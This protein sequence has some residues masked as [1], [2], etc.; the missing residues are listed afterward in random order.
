MHSCLLSVHVDTELYGQPDIHCEQRGPTCDGCG[1]TAEK[2]RRFCLA[3]CT[4]YKDAGDAIS[5]DRARNA[6]D[7]D[8]LSTESISCTT[9]VGQ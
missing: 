5:K 1:R 2:G 9:A 4:A 6:E 8:T 7:A 3:L